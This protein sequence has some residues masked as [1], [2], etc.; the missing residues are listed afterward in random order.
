MKESKGLDDLFR[1]RLQQAEVTVRDDFWD[2]LQKDLPAVEKPR[3]ML[4]MPMFRR[5]AAVALVVLMLGTAGVL[6]WHLT[7]R[8]D[9]Q[10]AFEQVAAY[11]PMPESDGYV[12]QQ[13]VTVRPMEAT[14]GSTSSGQQGGTLAA[15][16]PDAGQETSSVS[17]R[18]S[19]T[20][21]QQVYQHRTYP[22]EGR[23]VRQSQDGYLPAGG[24]QEDASV[25]TSGDDSRDDKAVET[26][27]SSKKPYNWAWKTYLGSSLPKD[28][29]RMP[30]TVGMAFERRLNDVLSVEAGLQY[31]RLHRQAG[32]MDAQ[33]LHTLA[34]PVRLDVQ[35]AQAGRFGFYATAGGAVEKC[36]AG[37]ADNS[38]CAEPLQLSVA[39]G[40]G[41]RYHLN[42]RLALFAEPTVTH[43][44][45]TDS[46]TRTLRSE[47]PTNFNLLCGLRMSY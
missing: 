11:Q 1:R 12:P 32:A 38:F 22:T 25:W 45:G 18:F 23:P 15:M 5:V 17:V 29:Y 16:T 47:R 40:V 4:W 37:A 8:E 41:V 14:V 33:T 24:Q 35:L 13:P 44:F 19:V 21:S 42:D 20:I 2:E 3:R 36:V 7:P 26:V 27:T 6:T 10:K 43:H 39:A 28:D 9:L 31:N 46:S 30:L 34:V